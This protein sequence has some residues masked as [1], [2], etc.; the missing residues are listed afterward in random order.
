MIPWVDSLLH[1]TFALCRQ[2]ET[3]SLIQWLPT[4]QNSNADNRVLSCIFAILKCFIA[5]SNCIQNACIET[6]GQTEQVG[7]LIVRSL[8]TMSHYATSPLCW[9]SFFMPAERFAN[10]CGLSGQWWR[11]RVHIGALTHDGRKIIDF[12]FPLNKYSTL[13]K[14]FD[15]FI[16][17]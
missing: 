13:L 15:R 5:W 4:N 7:H 11:R 16:I 14:I 6:Y 17:L 10:F 3:M 2:F 1:L 8:C 12:V 9:L